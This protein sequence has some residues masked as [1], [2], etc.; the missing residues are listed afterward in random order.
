MTP[1]VT[2]RTILSW[3]LPPTPTH[4]LSCQTPPYTYTLGM[5][6]SSYFCDWRY[7]LY[8][9]DFVSLLPPYTASYCLLIFVCVRASPNRDLNFIYCILRTLQV[10]AEVP[11]LEEDESPP[12]K[13]HCKFF[14]ADFTSPIPDEFSGSFS[15]ALFCWWNSGRKSMAGF[16]A[17]WGPSWKKFKG[18]VLW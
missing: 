15:V 11:F 3:P 7:I 13:R 4:H 1:A 6:Q 17:L 14:Y 8:K 10:E 16:W 9:C 12:V 2:V 18:K 5:C